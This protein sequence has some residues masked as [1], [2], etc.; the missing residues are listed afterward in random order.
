MPYSPTTWT[1]GV[2]AANASHMNNLEAQY[3]EAT[4][5]F[6]QDLFTAFVLTGGVGSKDGTTVNQLDVTSGAAFLLQ[7]DGTLRRRAWGASTAGQFTTSTPSTFYYLD[8]N[9]DG[10]FS[11]GTSHSGVANHL[12][13][14]NASTDGSGNINVVTDTRV[15]NTTLFNAGGGVTIAGTFNGALGGGITSSDDG[16]NHDTTIG[17]QRPA[18][19]ARS[20]LLQSWNGSAAQNAFSVGTGGFHAAA[21]VDDSGNL[22]KGSNKY[23]LLQSNGGGSAGQTLWVGTTDPTT[24]AAEGDVWV[25]A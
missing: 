20:L 16:T 18:G 12:T 25:K 21:Y 4:N 7:S 14:C 11:W 24:N 3:G 19:T 22:F 6:E 10:T 9:P 17:T 13:I 5:S 15:L 2:T 23:V 8:I 1:N